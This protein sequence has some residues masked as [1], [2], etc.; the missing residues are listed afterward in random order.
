MAA[1]YV[2]CAASTITRTALR[3]PDF[4]E[5]LAAAEQSAEIDAL[6]AFA[7][8]PEKTA[9]GGPPPGCWNAE[10]PMSSPA[11]HPTPSPP[12]SSSKPSPK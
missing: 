2:G 6:R 1:K 12:T 4:A 8:P 11:D 7:P 9:T 10:T 5:Q 3:D